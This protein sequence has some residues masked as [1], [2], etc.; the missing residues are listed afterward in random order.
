M[1]GEAGKS[2][3]AKDYLSSV[4]ALQRVSRGVGEQFEH[5]D[6]LLSPVCATPPHRLGEVNMD[7][8][9]LEP[10]KATARQHTGYTS[11]WNVTGQPAMSVPLHWS[12]EG[13][14]VGV[15]FV[16]R[17]GDEATLFQLGG[18]LERA[19]PW[20]DRLPTAHLR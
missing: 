7:A 10:Y 5:W 13:L 20:F 9:E 15:Q 6:V 14:P 17:F 3:T 4:Q 19:A 16:G 11:I 18:Q 1:F 8:T 12:E 2:V